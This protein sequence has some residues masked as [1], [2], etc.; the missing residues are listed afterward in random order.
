VSE[1]YVY[2]TGDKILVRGIKYGLVID[3]ATGGLH[4]LNKP[5]CEILECSGRAISVEKAL[6][7]L[8]LPPESVEGFLQEMQAKELTAVA[9]EPQEV[10]QTLEAPPSAA[11]DFIWLEVTSRCNLRCLHCYAEAAPQTAAEPSTGELLDWMD[12]AAALGCK[13]IQLTGGECTLRADLPKLL[14]HA[15]PKFETIEIFTNATL[16]DEPLIRFLAENQ[17][18]VAFSFYSYKSETHDRIAGVPGSHQKTLDSLKLLLAYDVKVR[19]GIIGLKQ[20]EED[21]EATEFFLRE[22]GVQAGAADPVRPCGRGRQQDFWP[23]NYGQCVVRSKPA[24]LP[25]RQQYS[26]SQ[27]W[28]SCWFGKAAISPQGDVLPCVFARDQVAGNLHEHSLAWIFQNGLRSYWQLTRDK[29]DV[30]LDCEYRYICRDCRPWAYGYTGDLYAKSPTC[31]YD[32]Y[33]GEW[34][35]PESALKL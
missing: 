7:I 8:E 32:P 23:E 18:Q 17:V 29:V 10:S 4:R 34:G 33:T 2:L 9:T 19:G 30:C 15:R 20:N 11:L 26:C 31:T 22:L 1:R 6:E 13:T 21:L 14:A 16:L 28:N 5:A 3:F 35:S 27:H 25:V 12:Q 24:F